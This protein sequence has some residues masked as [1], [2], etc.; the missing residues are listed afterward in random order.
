MKRLWCWEGLGAGGE[1]DYRGWD[2]WMES[3]TQW[4]WV[5]VNSRSWSWTGRP[6]VLRFMG[7]KRFGHDWATEL[8]WTDNEWCWASFQVFVSHL[9]VFF[10]KILFSSSA[11]FLIGSFIFLVLSCV[12]CLYIFQVNFLSV[13][14]FA[15]IISHSEGCLFTFL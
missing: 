12:S 14:S 6:G 7:L 15:I 1:G 3:R 5:S 2:G 11:H 9:Y 10:G 13:A 8:N 4:M